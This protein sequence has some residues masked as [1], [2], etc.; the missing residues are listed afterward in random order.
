MDH[1]EALDLLDP[2]VCKGREV[3]LDRR[4]QMEVL[5]L[6]VVQGLQELLVVRV[7]LARQECQEQLDLWVLLVTL[8]IWEFRGQQARLVHKEQ[9]VYL[10]QLDLSVNWERMDR[11]DH[12]DLVET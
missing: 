12:K 10:V 7:H 1:Q 5:E 9:P 4:V 2:P 8:E 3:T 11:L 6:V